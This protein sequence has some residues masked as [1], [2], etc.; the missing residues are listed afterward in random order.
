MTSAIMDESAWEPVTRFRLEDVTYHRAVDGAT[1]RVALD[2]PGVRNAFCPRTVD[3]LYTAINHARQQPQV[4]C[5]LL[6]GNGPSPDD[7]GW[8]S[9]RAGIRPSG[10][11]PAMNTP[12]TGRRTIGSAGYTFSMSSDSSGSC[13]NQSLRSSQAGPWVAATR[14]TWCVI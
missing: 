2:R 6:T 3:D 9:H 1:V 13:R 14:Y 10:A 12:M 7:G 4:G 11:V 8:P 5:V